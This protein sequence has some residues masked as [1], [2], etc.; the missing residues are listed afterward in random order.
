MYLT[1]LHTAI[2]HLIFSVIANMHLTKQH[3]VV[4]LL[5]EGIKGKHGKTGLSY[6]RYGEAKIVAVIDEES[7][8]DS[9]C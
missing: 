5:H 1:Q 8:G 7:V 2:Y 3:R 9:Y 4:I 6:L